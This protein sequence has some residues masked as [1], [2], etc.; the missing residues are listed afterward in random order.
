MYTNRQSQILKAMTEGL[1]LPTETTS[2]IH[3][4]QSPGYIDSMI[5]THDFAVALMGAI[6]QAVAAIGER[7][8]LDGQRVKVDR[9]HAGLL[10]NE[11]AYFF[12]SGWQFDI[13]AV[14]T[15]V[16]SFY[17]T[18]DGR[19]IFFNGAYAHLREG[20]LKFLDCP[21]EHAAIAQRVAHYNAQELEDELSNRGLCAAIL[22]S[23]EEWHAHPQ[24]QALAV[25]PPIELARFGRTR[26]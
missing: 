1:G 24:G 10:F 12:Q 18:R 8:G 14:H 13:S 11:I 26:S 2:E 21:N 6:G 3:I 17:E 5:E 9:R 25:V 22:R 7:R 20:I 16:N 15:P 19:Q 23:L 4:V